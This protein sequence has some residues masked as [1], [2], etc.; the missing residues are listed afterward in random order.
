MQSLTKAGLYTGF[1]LI[2]EALFVEEILLMFRSKRS[3]ARCAYITGCFAASASWIT[4]IT[5][6]VDDG[7]VIV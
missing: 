2:S 1:L 7:V 4:S 3:M 6:L 5:T